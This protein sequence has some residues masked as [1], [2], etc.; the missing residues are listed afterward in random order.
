MIDLYDYTRINIPNAMGARY[1]NE[2]DQL[3]NIENLTAFGESEMASLERGGGAKNKF[4]AH[5]L[6]PP[7]E[8]IENP[9]VPNYE[10]DYLP[11]AS[12]VQN[13]KVSPLGY[14]FQ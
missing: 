10:L 9:Q 1:V 11:V 3:R 14:Q 12:L 7:E 13:Q 4:I 6:V 2:Q 5:P 8:M